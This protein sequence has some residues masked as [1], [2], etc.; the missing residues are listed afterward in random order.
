M[1][2]KDA[3]GQTLPR[4]PGLHLLALAVDQ[5]P[6]KL[7]TTGVNVHLG[8]PEPSGALPEVSTN[9]EGHDDE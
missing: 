4:R 9:P 8:G 2:L 7:T 5:V 6:V 1:R 3:G